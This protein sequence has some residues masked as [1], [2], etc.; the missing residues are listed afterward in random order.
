MR[1]ALA[2]LAVTLVVLAVGALAV[3]TGFAINAERSFARSLSSSGDTKVR[4]EP[5]VTISGFPA[6]RSI[7]DGHY[8]AIGIT[9]RAVDLIGAG[10]CTEQSPCHV[11]LRSRLTDVRI[12]GPERFFRRS[13]SF[14]IG[15]EK[16]SVTLDS[17][18]VGRLLGIDDLTVNTPA[19]ENK[20]GGGGPQ[21]GLLSRTSGVLLTGSV[22]PE[23]GRPKVKVSVVVDLS[24]VGGRLRIFATD[25]YD[26]P[27]EHSDT[28]VPDEEREAVLRKFSAVL[29][30]LPMPWGSPPKSARSS[31]S[32]IVVDGSGAVGGNLSMS[33]FITLGVDTYIL[34]TDNGRRPPWYA[35]GSAPP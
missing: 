32:D 12:R 1:K 17:V 10:T 25:F 24:I 30:E 19:P 27:A 35:D 8:S 18:A 14:D 22:S 28:T 20:A 31:G 7:A 34:Y 4:Y 15:S 13:T 2:Y 21:D 33:I 16:G 6:V 26:G 23:P 11:D 5:E 29:P 3:D 9:A